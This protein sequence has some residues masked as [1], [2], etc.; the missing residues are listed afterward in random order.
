MQQVRRGRNS[1]WLTT[2][3]ESLR[4]QLDL[5]R[6]DVERCMGPRAAAAG[7]MAWAPRSALGYRWRAAPLLE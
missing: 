7:A 2:P 3:S 1:E 4:V 6:E 5:V